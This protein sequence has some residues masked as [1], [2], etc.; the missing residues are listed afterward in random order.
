MKRTFLNFTCFLALGI[1]WIGC[2]ESSKKENTASE[3]APKKEVCSYSYINDSTNV[4][5]TA[6]KHTAKVGVKGQFDSFT[7]NGAK[8][9]ESVEDVLKSLSLSVDV[10]SINSKDSI[11]DGKLVKLFFEI[12]ANTETIT[13]S[14]NSAENG[15][16]SMS[17]KMNDIENNVPFKYTLTGN[18][19]EL[20]STIDVNDWKGEDALASLQKA[21]EAKHTG[22]DGES[23]LWSEVGIYITTTLNKTCK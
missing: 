2:K 15:E 9:G 6:Y 11:R 20:K 13:G 10:S 18:K 23:K 22:G 17:F 14:V 1:G 8:S 7:A 12:M 21:C 19:L 5:W 16:G 3:T 4:H